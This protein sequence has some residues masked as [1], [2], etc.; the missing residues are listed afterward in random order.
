MKPTIQKKERHKNAPAKI[1]RLVN[2]KTW[3]HYKAEVVGRKGKLSPDDLKEAIALFKKDN[4]AFIASEKKKAAEETAR[5]KAK[6]AAKAL[7]KEARGYKGVNY[8]PHFKRFDSGTINKGW[9][10]FSRNQAPNPWQKHA[11]PAKP[12]GKKPIS[13]PK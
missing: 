9:N 5:L 2:N 4:G 8:D 1:T 13:R 11:R 6:E 3:E 7:A 10:S 12:S